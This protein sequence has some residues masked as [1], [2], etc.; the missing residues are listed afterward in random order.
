MNAASGLDVTAEPAIER[1]RSA[2]AASRSGF[3]F[4]MAVA[5][6]ITVVLGF[7]PS[8]YLR[9]F[10]ARHLSVPP[11]A[12]L[13]A[14]LPLVVTHGLAF[15]TWMALLLAQTGLV[16]TRRVA[17]HRRLGVLAAAWA[18]LIVIVTVA[19]AAEIGRTLN[20]P[21]LPGNVIA[22]VNFLTLGSLAEILIFGSLLGLAV[23]L[24]RRPA[25]HR[26][27]TIL[28]T[29]SM[30][31]P[32]TG[33]IAG[34]LLAQLVP[35]LGLPWG[36]IGTGMSIAFVVAIALHDLLTLR[37]VHPATV[38]GAVPY[39]MLEALNFTPFYGSAE[40]SALTGWVANLPPL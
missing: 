17:L 18:A 25:V 26:R 19:M 21:G 16:R 34:I 31:Q 35:G 12:R 39:L 40:A 3:Y 6:S 4:G 11:I 36:A 10:L 23:G 15:T 24:R 8:F 1:N 37:R 30:T 7:A 32:A 2:P 22:Q 20:T 9:P 28:A 14:S 29:V 33:R 13:G 27:L 38:W 5:I